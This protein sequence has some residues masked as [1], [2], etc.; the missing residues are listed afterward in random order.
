MTPPSFCPFLKQRKW[1]GVTSRPPLQERAGRKGPR[2]RRRVCHNRAEQLR[3]YGSTRMR[4]SMRGA[5]HLQTSPDLDKVVVVQLATGPHR[6]RTYGPESWGAS[7]LVANMPR[8]STALDDST[9]KDTADRD[10][11]QFWKVAGLQHPL[12]AGGAAKR[13]WPPSPSGAPKLGEATRETLC[14][15]L[16]QKKTVSKHAQNQTTKRNGRKS[17]VASN[18]FL[19]KPKH[20]CTIY[21]YTRYLHAESVSN[22]MRIR[23]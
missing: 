1:G 16:Q 10:A 7:L 2:S 20:A 6:E 21:T 18:T 3:P 13:L 23:R 19:K 22:K 5:K 14:R 4:G 11:L 12:A 8:R 17:H 15:T 9:R